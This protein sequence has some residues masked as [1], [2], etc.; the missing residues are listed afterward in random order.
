VIMSLIIADGLL[1]KLMQI[2]EEIKTRGDY[3]YISR[4]RTTILF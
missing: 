4:A 1:L 3:H 2:I